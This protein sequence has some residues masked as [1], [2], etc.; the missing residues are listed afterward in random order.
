MLAILPLILK[1]PDYLAEG[2]LLF[3]K[4]NT[5]SSLVGVSPEIS[6]LESVAQ[7]QSSPLNTEAE[8]I[9]STPLVQE[10]IK[11]LSLQDNKGQPLK[12][13]D[14]L[15]DLTV[16]GIEQ[17]D[18]LT[19][20]YKDTNPKIAARVVNTLINVYLESNVSSRRKEAAAAR[21]F[22]EKQVPKAE[23]AV[24]QSEAEL[25]NFKEKN[26]VVSLE[27]EAEKSLEVISDLQRRISEAKSKIA[28]ITSQS[29]QIRKQLGMNSQEAVTMAFLSQ[30]P[31]V[32]DIIKEIQQ[33]ESQLI[34]RR[35]VLQ[36]N[37][38]EII[39]LENNLASSKE[40]LQKRVEEV[41]G[42]NQQLSKNLQMGTLQQK[43]AEDLIRL[44]SGR[45]GLASE[46]TTLSQLEVDYRQ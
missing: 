32:Q 31:G 5:V 34:S 2:K 42:T 1:R 38:P 45:L 43:L 13:K 40:L 35:N 16:E 26:K 18:I 29:E 39:S 46:I 22:I 3:Q 15:E 24:R 28:D 19:V 11:L 10:T 33:L 23:S 21:K 17:T 9:R 7:E 37:H 6:K 27:E 36:D 8:V 41:V 14:F 25:A 44:E 12:I 20:S 4:T 30:S